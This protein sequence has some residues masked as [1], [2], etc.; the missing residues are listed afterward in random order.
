[1]GGDWCCLLWV[2]AKC[3]SCGF[4]DRVVLCICKGM[5]M[6]YREKA[7]SLPTVISVGPIM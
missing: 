1:M 3:S 4:L 2:L 6:G 5:K 7:E